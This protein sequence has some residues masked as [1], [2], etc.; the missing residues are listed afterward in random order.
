MPWKMPETGRTVRLA[1]LPADIRSAWLKGDI[2]N[3]R[4][5]KSNEPGYVISYAIS[6][7][8]MVVQIGCSFLF[9][10]RR[11]GAGS[12]SSG[13]VPYYD[14]GVSDESG[15]L[16]QAELGNGIFF[17]DIGVIQIMIPAAAMQ[18]LRTGTYSAAL[19]VTDSVNTRQMFVGQ[20]PVQWGGVSRGPVNSQTGAFSGGFSGGFS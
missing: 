10:I 17:V 1:E 5:D 18:K 11:S 9:E 6:T 16:L 2:E 4:F 15:P 8:F 3:L 7:G 14:V 20:L 13:Y 19:V 12:D